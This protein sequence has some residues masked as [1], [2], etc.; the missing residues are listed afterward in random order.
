M[1]ENIQEE[2]ISELDEDEKISQVRKE[3]E[4]YSKARG[5]SSE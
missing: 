4:K 3:T 2:A 5:N 1:H